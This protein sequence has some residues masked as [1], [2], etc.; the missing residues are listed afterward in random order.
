MSNSLRHW[1]RNRAGPGM[2]PKPRLIVPGASMPIH[3]TFWPPWTGP[4]A[5]NL[6]DGLPPFSVF[7]T[8]ATSPVSFAFG[9][10]FRRR[11]FRRSALDPRADRRQGN[12]VL[13]PGFAH[14][15]GL[16][17]RVG[18]DGGLRARLCIVSPATLGGRDCSNHPEPLATNAL[19]RLARRFPLASA[20][21]DLPMGARVGFVLAMTALTGLRRAVF[22]TNLAPVL[23]LLA[24]V[25]PC[26]RDFDC[27]P[28][29][30]SSANEALR[31]GKLLDDHQL[32]VIRCSFPCVTK[33][34]WCPRSHAPLRHSIIPPKARHQV[35]CRKRHPETVRAPPAHNWEIGAFR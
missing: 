4:I 23:A 30:P 25:L 12:P 28:P 2:W 1:P 34:I 24:L 10:R 17:A 7:S 3:S 21:L 31:P 16:A 15:R 33:R 14:L 35:R 11:P 27:G 18:E 5:R 9:R 6:I 29:S 13:S 32:P 8:G 19:Q 22:I 20:H 26:P